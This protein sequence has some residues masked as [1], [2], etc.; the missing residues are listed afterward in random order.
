MSVRESGYIDYNLLSEE[1]R[2]IIDS[3]LDIADEDLLRELADK[4]KIYNAT[5]AELEAVR[6]EIGL[7]ISDYD[8]TVEDRIEDAVKKASQSIGKEIH[9]GRVPPS[10]LSMIWI[11]TSDKFE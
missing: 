10:D 11:D 4:L 9:I 6:A 5:K 2:S 7:S 1:L 3:K 8:E